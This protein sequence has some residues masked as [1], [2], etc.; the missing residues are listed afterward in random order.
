M[1][2]WVMG[3]AWKTEAAGWAGLVLFPTFPLVIVT[4]GSET[5]LVLALCLW[6]FALAA[7]GRYALAGLCAGLAFVARADAS[8]VAPLI[9]V[10]A[11]LAP[12]AV[13]S[14][15]GLVV[16]WLI[17]VL[18]W[19]IFAAA[20]FGSPLPATLAVKQ[21][22]GRMDISQQFV[23]GFA[24]VQNWYLGGWH[25]SLEAVLAGIGVAMLA[26]SV[27]RGQTAATGL[28]PVL[29]FIWSALY[30]A[31]YTALGVSAYFWYYAPLVPG[32]VA[33]LGMGFEA[34]FCAM[35]RLHPRVAALV[36]A[37]LV[38]VMCFMQARSAIGIATFAA[39]KRPPIYR[40]AGE[41]LN[42]NTPPGA[43]VGALE[44]GIIGYY[45]HRPMIDFAG[46]IQ[47]GL[48]QSIQPKTTYDDLAILAVRKL[49]PQ[50]VVV[51]D[52]S[53]PGLKTE[54]EQTK[55]EVVARFNGAEYDFGQNISI[56]KC[57]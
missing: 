36:C 42:A 43:N 51:L 53:L 3:R 25:I 7:R 48:A 45:A 9:G 52:G 50:F 15:R 22:Q 2:F 12:G 41:W 30:F 35:R 47:P 31:A 14:L 56:L 34:V 38:G 10:M 28:T 37:G 57:N 44:V 39:D 54:L 4:L 29:I 13:K 6:A 27:I 26:A 40:A 16:A 17:P 32:F 55:C 49:H 11:L 20:Y 5:P 46:L 18:V 23:Q 1:T 19:M 21:A 24:T 33:A 8:I